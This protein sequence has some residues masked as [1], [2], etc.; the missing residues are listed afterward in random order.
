MS[1]RNATIYLHTPVHKVLLQRISIPATA[2]NL[3]VKSVNTPLK[4]LH[5]VLHSRIVDP[6]MG[7]QPHHSILRGIDQHAALPAA[8]HNSQRGTNDTTPDK[9]DP[10]AVTYILKY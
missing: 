7:H 5:N 4:H 8:V 3:N 2:Q 9:A 1:I 6:V 10:V